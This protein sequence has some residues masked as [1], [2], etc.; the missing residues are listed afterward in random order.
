M[1]D[2]TTIRVINDGPLYVEGPFKIVTASGKEL[3]VEGGKCALCRCG[4]S[5]NK[6]FCDG[7][8]KKAGFKASEEG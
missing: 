1:G 8:H 2:P 3:S 4:G 7:A 5:E 6:P